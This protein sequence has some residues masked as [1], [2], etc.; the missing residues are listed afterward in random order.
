MGNFEISENEEDLQNKINTMRNEVLSRQH[1]IEQYRL[2]IN[3]Y[4]EML[5]KSKCPKLAIPFIPGKKQPYYT[6][7]IYGNIRSS[8]YLL[9]DNVI[10]KLGCYRSKNEAK[11]AYK[12]QIA[13]IEL[14]MLCDGL[15]VEGEHFEIRYDGSVFIP[16]KLEFINSSYRFLTYKSC[17]CA[18]DI[19]GHDKLKLTF[20]IPLGD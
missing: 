14:L 11:L 15:N 18:I 1:E 3:K 20:N 6:A 9:E 2:E 13:D 5:E 16:V 12:K 7:D 10:S 17:K 4:E 8:F 19:M